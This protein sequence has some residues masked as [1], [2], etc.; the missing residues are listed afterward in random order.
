MKWTACVLTLFLSACSTFDG[1]R[2]HYTMS[3]I[4]TESGEVICCAV[5][6]KNTKNIGRVKARGLR[7]PDGTYELILEEDGV[8]ASSP[9][10]VMLEQQ[11][12]QTELLQSIVPLLP[13]AIIPYGGVP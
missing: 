9:M 5:D 7:M 1:G 11:K 8:D 4:I 2:A 6:I 10:S 3:P 13:K 12:A